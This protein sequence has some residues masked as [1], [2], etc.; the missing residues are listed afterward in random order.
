MLRESLTEGCGRYALIQ[1]EVT[2]K[3]VFRW[4]DKIGPDESHAKELGPVTLLIHLKLTRVGQQI[5]VFSST[6]GQ[7]WDEPLMTHTAAFDGPGRLGLFTCSG[8]TF[9]STTSVF[10]SIFSNQR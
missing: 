10:D 4:R 6:D 5:Q 2:G 7:K 3:L 8:I 1:V 9:A